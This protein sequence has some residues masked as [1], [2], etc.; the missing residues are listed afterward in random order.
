MVDVNNNEKSVNPLPFSIKKK[1]RKSQ[2]VT[3]TLPQSQ[4]PEASG[5][6]PQKR[7]KPKSKKPPTKTKGIRKSQPFPEGTT[8]DPK[9]LGGNVQPADKGLPST[10]FDERAAKT[11]SFPGGSR[12]DEDLDG[13]IPPTD[14][15]PQ[16][17]HVANLSRSG[18]EYQADE[19][20]STR[21][22]YQTLT[23][24]KGKTSSEVKPGLETL[25]LTTLAD[26]QA[27]LLFEDE[28]AQES[29][30]EEVFAAGDDLEEDTQ[31]DK[32]EHQSPSPNIYKPEPSHILETQVSDSDSSS[33][34]LKKYDNT[35]P[36]TQRQLVKYLRKV[37]RVLFKKLTEEQWAHHEEDFVSYANLM[38]SIK[39]YYEENV[40][41]M[42]QTDK[43]IDAAMNSLDKNSIARGD[44]L[45]DLNG[46]TETLKAIQDVVKEDLVLN[47]KV[48]KATEAYT[49]NSTHLTELLTL[50]KNFDF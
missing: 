23:E 49:K 7:R 39:G 30:E 34:N 31:A 5:S 18:S 20:Q 16:T 10:V 4:G 33:P 6:L 48:I 26:I 40:D 44:L 3:S 14:M 21:L 2:T 46:V 38:A 32:E 36:L 15:E 17:N 37:S 28:L 13:L 19:T 25:Q 47:K 24:N 50:I 11:M 45:N 27:Y 29:D 43:V 41:H 35:L 42:E 1:T 12:E 9:D 22:G 8:T